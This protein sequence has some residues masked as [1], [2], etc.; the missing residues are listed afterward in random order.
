MVALI[1]MWTPPHFWALALFV[2]GDYGRAGVPMLTDDARRPR[3]PQPRPAYALLLVPVALALAL[4]PRSAGRSPR[5]ARW[6]CNAL[7][8][9]RRLAVWRRD[10][11]AAEA[12]G[13]A[14]EKASFGF[15]LAYLFLH[16]APL[17]A[18]AA[19]ARHRL[20][21]AAG[22]MAIRCVEHESHRRR[23]GRNSASGLCSG[24]SWRWSSA[25]VVKV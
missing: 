9:A 24:A 5:R 23:L 7:F 4:P 15:S 12:D 14:A 20:G 10:G 6:C 17:M 25:D 19:L 21:L 22:L 16:F 11:A 8:L 2:K 1:F 18:D 3:H 13:W